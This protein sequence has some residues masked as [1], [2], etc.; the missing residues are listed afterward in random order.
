LEQPESESNVRA[1]EIPGAGS[2][3]AG[4]GYFSGRELKKICIEMEIR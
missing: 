4:A 1:C 3:L 2:P